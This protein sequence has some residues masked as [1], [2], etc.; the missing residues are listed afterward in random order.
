MGV[1]L[2]QPEKVNTPEV[3]ASLAETRPDLLVVVA[4]GAILKPA[5]LELAAGGAIN[6]HASLLPAYRGAAPINWALAAG[7][8]FTGVTTI[9]LSEAMDAGDII[10]QRC[11]PVSPEE[12][13]GELSARLSVLGAAVLV[14]TLSR[15]DRGG[16]PRTP[17]DPSRVTFAPRL[18]KEDGHIDWTQGSIALHNRI[19]AM[20]PWPGALTHVAGRALLIRKA[21]PLDRVVRPQLEPGAVLE[22]ARD[23]PLVVQSGEGALA[24]EEV[25]PEN[26]RVMSGAEFA[27]GARLA[28]GSR[29]GERP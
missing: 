22:I 27:R 14:E 6:V 10:L 29:L 19:R 16:A 28:P 7:E 1:L 25:Q 3:V 20:T 2:L 5:L 26:R 23:G 12:N 24:L 18:K 8:S 15:L 4:F 9:H 17:Q 13:A 11:A 21:R